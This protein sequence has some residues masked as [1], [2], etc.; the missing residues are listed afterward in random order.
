MILN[1]IN[2]KGGCTKEIEVNIG[3]PGCKYDLAQAVIFEVAF[4]LAL[5]VPLFGSGVSSGFLHFIAI[6]VDSACVVMAIVY[7]IAYRVN[8]NWSIQSTDVSKF[9]FGN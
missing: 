6:F 8:E 9:T 3:T 4:A 2:E 5:V 7:I 1:I